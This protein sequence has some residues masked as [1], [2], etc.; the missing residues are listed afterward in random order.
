[1]DRMAWSLTASIVAVAIM[2]AGCDQPPK[3]PTPRPSPDMK[4]VAAQYRAIAEQAN[5]EV[6]AVTRELS[7]ETTIAQT[8]ASYG[9]LGAIDRAVDAKLKE[10][11]FP[12]SMDGDVQ[13][14]LKANGALEDVFAA[15]STDRIR[16]EYD[17]DLARL[18]KATEVFRAARD[19]VRKDLGL[20]T[21]EVTPPVEG[22]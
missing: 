11:A 8:K 14:L 16:G 19:Q 10:I 21:F 12:A 22:P 2:L 5:T 15:L 1:M 17:A 20:P 7:G 13:R 3:T 6:G 9:K 4:T 18:G